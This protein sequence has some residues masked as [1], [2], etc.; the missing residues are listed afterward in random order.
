M[1]K[2]ASCAPATSRELDGNDAD[3]LPQ[4]VPPSAVRLGLRVLLPDEVQLSKAERVRSCH[5][6]EAR[7]AHPRLARDLEH[8]EL[9]QP[10]FVERLAER[11]DLSI[12]ADKGH[13]VAG[14][15][16]SRACRRADVVRRHGP[17]LPLDEQR[18]SLARVERSRRVED[19]VRREDLPVVGPGGQPRGEIDRVPHDRVG[20]PALRP[21]VA[22]EDE[23][24][25][26]A[27]AE[28][29]ARAPVDDLPDGAQH[30]LRVISGARRRTRRQIQLDR[31]DIDVGLEPRDPVGLARALDRGPDLVQALQEPLG[32]MLPEQL[33]GAGELQKRHGD[34]AVLGLA[35]RHRE[36]VAQRRRDVLVEPR[37]G[38]VGRRRDEARRRLEPTEQMSAGALFD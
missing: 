25:V 14:S 24:A 29:D 2:A 16:L 27:G 18:L 8:A 34:M 1:T 36:V 28:R 10:G 32:S 31:A 12:A 9:P 38:D 6:D 30:A 23:A 13:L 4:R 5:G 7:L 22:G 35:A 37:A 20:A 15:G 17:L 33:V 21:D 3:E 11:G 26:D 19:V